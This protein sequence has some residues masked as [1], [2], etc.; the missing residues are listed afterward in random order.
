MFQRWKGAATSDV[1]ARPY[2]GPA[3]AFPYKN[4]RFLSTT[5]TCFVTKPCSA[6]KRIRLYLFY[7][8]K[9]TIAKVKYKYCCLNSFTII[10]VKLLLRLK[11]SKML[12][13]V[14][15]KVPSNFVPKPCKDR[16]L[17]HYW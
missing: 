1:V 15:L 4:L 11:K 16:G 8:V 12:V 6:E 14:Y 5:H 9:F 7:N 3:A 10:L 2:A 17:T 13:S